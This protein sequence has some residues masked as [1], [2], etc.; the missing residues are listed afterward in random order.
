MKKIY[1]LTLAFIGILGTVQ[2]QTPCDNGRYY[3]ELFPNVTITNGVQF[4]SNTTWTGANMDLTMD[5]YEPTGDTETERPL[6][7][8]AHGGSFIAGS[9]EDGDVVALATAFAKKGFVCVSIDYRTGMF[10]IDSV[11]AVKAVV[12]ATQDMKGSIRFFYEDKQN[13][14]TY[15]IDTNNIIIGGSSAGAVTALH[16]AYLDKDCEVEQYISNA[17]LNAMGG[18]EGTSGSP[19]YSTNVHAVI[20]L[21]GALASYG[22][23]EPGDVPFCSLH[24]DDDGTVPYYTDVAVVA[25]FNVIQLDGSRILNE[26]AN[27]IGIQNNFYTHYGAGHAVYATSTAYMDTTIKFVTDF[28]VDHLACSEPI[29]QPDNAPTGAA[30]LYP[31][32]YCGLGINEGEIEIKANIFPNPSNNLITVQLE[33]TSKIHSIEI[34]DLSG[35]SIESVDLNASEYTIEKNGIGSGT[36]IIKITDSEGKTGTSRIIFN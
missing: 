8:W 10:P 19:G 9:R 11:N 29:L 2:A 1:Y 18:L 5:I 7:I 25:G 24:G 12:R 34:L 21:C 32:T 27:A 6:I 13:S 28:L 33:G 31:L 14:N 4:G 16:L 22:W 17:D 3:T 15:K 26:Q 20:N 30:P 36:Y 35:R 23:M